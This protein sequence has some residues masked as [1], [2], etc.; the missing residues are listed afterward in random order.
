MNDFWHIDATRDIDAAVKNSKPTRKDDDNN[1][2]VF[3]VFNEEL[4]CLPVKQFIAECVQFFI[5]GIPSQAVVNVSVGYVGLLAPNVGKDVK[6]GRRG[7]VT[8]EE[9][10][11]KVS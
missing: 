1:E 3:R 9:L 2:Q 5:I 4:L 11:K 10:C 6:E 7:A 8:M